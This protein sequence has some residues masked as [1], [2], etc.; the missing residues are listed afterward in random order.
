MQ[1]RVVFSA[2][3]QFRQGVEECGFA[4]VWQP[5]DTH[6]QVVGETT[7]DYPLLRRFLLAPFR[8]HFALR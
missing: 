7:E 8:R 6:L 4:D 3:V 2:D 5:N 1:E